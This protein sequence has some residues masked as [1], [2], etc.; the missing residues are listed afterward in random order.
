MDPLDHIHPTPAAWWRRSCLAP[1]LA[2]YWRYLVNRQY[3]KETRRGYVCAV[4]HFARW[5]SRGRRRAACEL[6]DDDIRRFLD[7][8]LPRCTCP[9]PVRR[10]RHDMRAA[11]HHLLAAL[12][13]AGVLVRPPRHSAVDAE[14]FAFDSYLRDVRGLALNTR[15]QRLHIVRRLLLGASGTNPKEVAPLSARR[16]RRFLAKE[17]QRWRPASGAVLASTLRSYVRFRM[18]CGDSVSHLMP[19]IT[20]PAR[21]RLAPLPD[22]LSPTEVA[23]LLACFSPDIPSVRRAYAMVRCIVDLGLR[24]HEVVS[25]RLDDVDWRAGVLRIGPTKARRVDVL[26]LPA[27]TGRAIAAYL[28]GERPRTANRH[29]FVRHVAPVDK[30]IGP[31]VARRAVHDAYRRAGLPYTRVHL[32]RHTLASRVLAGGGTL[33]EVADVLRHRALD[34]S[35]IYTKIDTARLSAMALPWPGRVP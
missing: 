24:A 27:A 34:T 15:A 29:V 35:L 28:R 17:L 18:G 13:E 11:L 25:L 21:W 20:S 1:V 12:R 23:R 3:P 9:R 33:K 6:T 10:C 14:L 19:V 8:H 16:L 4:A 5:L 31:S 30:P 32:L 7:E 22:V 26:P 2:V